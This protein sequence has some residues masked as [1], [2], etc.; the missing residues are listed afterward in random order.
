MTA[1]LTSFEDMENGPR[2]TV[3]LSTMAFLP[4]LAISDRPS[5]YVLMTSTIHTML[6]SYQ[7]GR[8]KN[9][10]MSSPAS[11]AVIVARF[12]KANHYTEVRMS[13]NLPYAT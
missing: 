13:N 12:L 5:T 10:N 4:N 9:Q 6:P 7:F 3:A 8:S 1:A 2:A 11:P